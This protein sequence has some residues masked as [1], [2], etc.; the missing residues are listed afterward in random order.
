MILLGWHNFVKAGPHTLNFPLLFNFWNSTRCQDVLELENGC[1]RR[2]VSLLGKFSY[3]TRRIRRKD[4]TTR[5]NIA[6]L[7]DCT[8]CKRTWGQ[9]T[10]HVGIHNQRIANRWIFPSP[11]FRQTRTITRTYLE[12]GILFWIEALRIVNR[13]EWTETNS[14]AK[15]E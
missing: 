5:C 1:Y 14:T 6:Y 10:F 3:L 12:D 15:L 2:F 9:K 7:S 13:K 4:W 11:R 8:E